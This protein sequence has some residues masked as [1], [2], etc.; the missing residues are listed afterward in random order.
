MTHNKKSSDASSIHQMLTFVNAVN[1]DAD[2]GHFRVLA[3][4]ANATRKMAE[5]EIGSLGT[6]MQASS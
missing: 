2:V 4:S 5:G 1:K 3:A 6:T